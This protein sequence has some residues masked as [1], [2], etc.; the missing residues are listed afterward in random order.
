MEQH[1]L[2]SE[3]NTMQDSVIRIG[4]VQWQMRQFRDIEA[5]YQQVEFLWM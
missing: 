2:H 1:L 5:F 3:E 4:L